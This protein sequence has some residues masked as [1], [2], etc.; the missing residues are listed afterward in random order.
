MMKHDTDATQRPGATGVSRAD[1]AIRLAMPAFLSLALAMSPAR[2]AEPQ[3]FVLQAS[4]FDA[5][6]VANDQGR[7]VQEWPG[8]PQQL[9]AGRW[10]AVDFDTS[11]SVWFDDA[12]RVSLRG[13][14]VEIRDGAFARHPDDP[15]QTPLFSAWS[16]AGT[17]LLRADGSTFTD[18]QPG[19]GEWEVTPHPQR[20]SWR[21]REAGERIFDAHGQLHLQIGA[22]QRRAAGPFPERAQYLICD[23]QTQA[24]CALR[25][26]AG[27]TLWAARVD[28][29]L[30]LDDGGWLGLQGEAWRRL[31]MDGQ[32]AGDRS[33][34]YVAGP[35]WPASR[36]T[37]DDS[38][39]RWP[40]WVT[41]YRVVQEDEQELAVREDNAVGGL[42]QSDGRFVAV[43]G[44]TSGKEVCPGAWRFAMGEAGDR[45]GGADGRVLGQVTAYSWSEIE[46]HPALRLAVADNGQETLVDCRGQRLVDTPPLIRL[47]AEPAGF[48]GTLADE[49]QPRLW[50]DAD[51]HQHLLPTG[52][53]ID[54][55]SRDGALLIV[56]SDAGELRLYDVG[57][58]RFVGE[59]FESAATLLPTGVVFLREGYY[60]FMDADGNE[61]LPP[62]YTAITPWGDDR[63]WSARYTDEDASISQLATLHRMDGAAIASWRDATVSDS[64]VLRNQPNQGPV[65][66]LVGRTF[67]TADGEF[68]GQQ[69]VNRDGQ[70]LFLAMR[71]Q[72]RSPDTEGAVIEPLTG[73]PRRH[74]A[75]CT[76]PD[77]IRAAM[78]ATANQ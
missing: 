16:E 56:R 24:P 77:D 11:R 76:I 9:A 25:D 14:Y 28:D 53:V 57:R 19:Q 63:L 4:G 17:A 72:R 23:V 70:T 44:A 67:E 73:P 33:R 8:R 46:G 18:W 48:V 7:L 66:E 47:T 29:V 39:G 75:P 40:R 10:V 42:M 30:P 61:R 22:D 41:E 64:A 21:S 78:A 34:I 27:N 20:Y 15:D 65:T 45:L 50:L 13:P 49:S 12:G 3:A 69:W 5:G 31:E 51:L 71:C 54:K 62:R 36:A 52:N 26:E 59:A 43:A 68:F 37:A 58:G 35:S 74:G 1:A 32:L 55:V 2:A 38:A 60:G 6:L